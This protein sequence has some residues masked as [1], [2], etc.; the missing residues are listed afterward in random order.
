MAGYTSGPITSGVSGSSSHYVGQ[1]SAKEAQERNKMEK[2][3]REILFLN[4]A[5]EHLRTLIKEKMPIFIWGAPGLGK[6]SI[7]RQLAEEEGI[8]FTDLR[9]SL[10]NPVDL[11]GLPYMDEKEKKATWLFPD[12]LPT[13][14]K[15]I[16]FLDELNTAPTSVQIAAYQLLLDRHIGKYIFPDG[17]RIIAAGNR[18]SDRAFV[19]K[20]PSPLANRLIHL[21]VEADIDDWKEWAVGKI[22][23]R[24][25]AFLN[26]RP[27]LLATLPKEEIKAYP[28]PRTWHY[29]SRILPLYK[30]PN[31]ATAAITGAIGSGATKEFLSFIQIWKDLPDVEDV[32]KGKIKSVPKKSDVLYALCSA[33]V[34]RLKDE[35][36]DNFLKYTL[37]MPVEFATLAVRDAV[38][39]KWQEQI[40]ESEH[41]EA[42]SN[43]F[44]EYL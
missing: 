8:G 23:Q 40:R 22:D 41:F 43:K 31:E 12:F 11:R 36:I 29:V 5:K 32:L 39:G 17:W 3:D 42:W 13:R 16:L 26:F 38:R 28:T 21:H 10:L 18:E 37:K 15:G 6:S 27:K 9:L 44:S 25:I 35:Y 33:L 14:G 34:V 4:Q 19:S 1:V 20:M 7:T 24:V 30:N 2:N